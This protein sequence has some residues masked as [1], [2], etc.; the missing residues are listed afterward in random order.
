LVTKLFQIYF[1]ILIFTSVNNYSQTRSELDNNK[2]EIKSLKKT[3]ENPNYINIDNKQ[4][5]REFID[6]SIVYPSKEKD[7]RFFFGISMGTPIGL[8]VNGSMMLDRFIIRGSGMVYDSKWFG[9]QGDLGYAFYKQ[10]PLVQSFS[11]VAGHYRVSPFNPPLGAGGQNSYQLDGPP[12]FQ[13]YDATYSDQLI[14]ASYSA[15]SVGDGIT[16]DQVLN[17]QY[18]IKRQQNFHQTYL[19]LTYD[20]YMDK[21]FFQLGA[22]IGSGSYRNPQLLF[23]V[24]YL[25]DYVR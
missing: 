4:E 3:R 17:Y 14:R 24:G 12:G 8:N 9:G 23:Q 15:V 10:G 20:L 16:L 19:G 11:I 1:L 21:F 13:N 22:G 25:F 18:G 7:N 5:V 2:N 6:S